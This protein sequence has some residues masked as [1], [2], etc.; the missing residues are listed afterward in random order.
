MNWS[1]VS[2]SVPNDFKLGTERIA[3]RLANCSHLSSDV[4][5]P[6]LAEGR[7]VRA[8]ALDHCEGTHGPSRGRRSVSPPQSARRH[9][10]RSAVA[11]KALRRQGHGSDPTEILDLSTYRLARQIHG[12]WNDPAHSPIASDLAAACCEA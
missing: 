5:F 6:P 1:S 2:N 10:R 3:S 8:L 12:I 7:N 11:R 4:C 9:A